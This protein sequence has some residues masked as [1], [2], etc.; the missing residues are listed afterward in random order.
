[1]DAY[2]DQYATLFRNGRKVVLLAVSADSAAELASWARDK[3]YPFRFLSDPDGTAGRLYGAW[4]PKYRLDNRTLYV[5]GRD[6]KIA[7]VAAPFQEI[8]PKAYED[9]KAAID[10]VAAR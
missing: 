1:M 8:D 2:R 7:Y 6:G 4:E 10:G 3:Q 9:L 5:V